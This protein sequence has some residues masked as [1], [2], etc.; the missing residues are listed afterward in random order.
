[1][2]NL[3]V[4]M[5]NV[6]PAPS[7]RSEGTDVCANTAQDLL[8]QYPPV[9]PSSATSVMAQYQDINKTI[10]GVAYGLVN[11]VHKREITHEI[12]KMEVL[13]CIKDRDEEITNLQVQLAQLHS[14]LTTYE[15]P[16]SFSDN[17]GRVPN[18]IPLSNG[19]FVPAKWV[20]QHSDT[21]VELLA[22]H[23]EGEHRYVV[24]LYT[25]PDYSLDAPAEPTP[26]WLLQLLQGPG[27]AFLTLMEAV[28]K[29][30]NWSLE[31][32]V[33]RYRQTLTAC[34]DLMAQCDAI[35][36]ELDLEE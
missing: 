16:D 14:T 10:R 5:H 21:K 3:R 20:R 26:I 30:V 12:A 25:V 31:A 18:L 23:E 24:E 13:A 11:T 36:A 35:N 34:D 7:A 29:L 28:E 6:S 8:D 4:H 22:G 19:L 17:D 2:S 1:M 27:D 32:E 33:Y 15:C 9:S